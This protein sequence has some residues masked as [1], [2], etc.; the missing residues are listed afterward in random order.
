MENLPDDFNG[1]TTP[2]DRTYYDAPLTNKADLERQAFEAEAE[3]AGALPWGYLKKQRT[4]NGYSV[5]VYNYM[6]W[7][8]YARAKQ[9]SNHD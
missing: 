3:R 2:S 7:G 9:E 5:Q 4:S 6:W 1:F 8:W